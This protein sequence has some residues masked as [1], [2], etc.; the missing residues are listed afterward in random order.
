MSEAFSLKWENFQSNVSRSFGLLKN[1]VYLHDVTLIGDDHHQVSAH[2]LILSACSEYF[3]NIFKYN[4]MPNVHPL[5]CL[6]G[7]SADDLNNVMEYIYNGEVKLYQTNL[8]RFL[9]VA[10]RLKLEG[11]TDMENEDEDLLENKVATKM[12]LDE[13]EEVASPEEV[14]SSNEVPYPPNSNT[15]VENLN[16]GEESS[17][18]D[19]PQQVVKSKEISSVGSKFQ[20]PQCD[21]LFTHNST[22][23]Q[24]IRNIHE[25]VKYDCNQCD[26][27][28]TKQT[29]L[30]IHI[31]SK[32]EGVKYGCT[33]CEFQTSQQRYLRAH[34][35]NKHEG[36]KQEGWK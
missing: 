19:A 36:V 22:V 14:A 29:H 11:M 8:K 25:G 3:K 1:E 28:A 24:H 15:S 5:L 20:C 23:H 18:A 10:Q 30:K 33:E 34:I 9:D 16:E 13:T 2:K 32:H 6:D 26:Y 7:V 12:E 4:S 21:K 27:Q 17:T 31:Q 35:Q